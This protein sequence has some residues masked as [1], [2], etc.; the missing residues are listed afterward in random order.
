[1]LEKT[2]IETAAIA[3]NKCINMTMMI[4]LLTVEYV[5]VWVSNVVVFSQIA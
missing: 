1:M 2:N 4:Y 5:F 3:F